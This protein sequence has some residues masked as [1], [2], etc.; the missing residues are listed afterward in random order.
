MLLKVSG[1]NEL[2]AEQEDLKNRYSH[3]EQDA[4]ERDI[5]VA[6]LGS[7]ASEVSSLY[8]LKPE[9][10]LVA[11]AS[12]DN[13]EDPQVRSSLDPLSTLQTLAMSGATSAGLSL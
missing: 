6:S 10:V 1:Y 13:V 5:Q 9:P 8:G 11:A 12:S 4:R 2:R 7:L 3:L